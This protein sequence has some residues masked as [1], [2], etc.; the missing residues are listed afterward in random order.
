MT[1][2]REAF[3][4]A[5]QNALNTLTTQEEQ[6]QEMSREE[7]QQTSAASYI[8]DF[9]DGVGERVNT[10]FIPTGFERLD[11]VLDGACMKG[12]TSWSGEVH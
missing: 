4:R 5:V 2:D 1:E 8:Q 6:Y 7:Y 3:A 9:M 11:M 12:S 10:S